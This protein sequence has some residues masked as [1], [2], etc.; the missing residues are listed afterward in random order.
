MNFNA[1]QEVLILILGGTKVLL[2]VSWVAFWVLLGISAC[3]WSVKSL[4]N[5]GSTGLQSILSKLAK[6]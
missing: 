2:W 6:I 5:Y 4:R 1:F 3:S